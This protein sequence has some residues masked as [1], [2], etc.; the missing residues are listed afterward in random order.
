MCTFSNG[1]TKEKK[2]KII[3]FNTEKQFEKINACEMTIMK[4][5]SKT[6]NLY[7]EAQNASIL[8]N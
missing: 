3:K 2:I 1:S 5:S 6:A 4:P 8:L 7:I